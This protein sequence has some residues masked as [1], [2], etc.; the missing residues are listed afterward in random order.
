MTAFQ[1]YELFQDVLAVLTFIAVLAI[2]VL[3]AR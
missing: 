1:Y 3:I 2:L